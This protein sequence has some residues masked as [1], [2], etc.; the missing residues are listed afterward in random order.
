[1]NRETASAICSGKSA[2]DQLLLAVL[3]AFPQSRVF[4]ESCRLQQADKMDGQEDRVGSIVIQLTAGAAHAPAPWSNPW[5]L[6]NINVHYYYL[7][8]LWIFVSVQAKKPLPLQMP[9][10]KRLHGGF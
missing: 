9:M 3:D 4:T 5:N 1:M 2:N 8:L 6:S 10:L 7:E